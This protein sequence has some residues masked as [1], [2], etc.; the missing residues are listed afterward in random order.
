MLVVLDS[1]V[2]VRLHLLGFIFSLRLSVSV[3]KWIDASLVCPSCF[4]MYTSVKCSP[5]LLYQGSVI[6]NS[7]A[8][9]SMC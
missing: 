5:S 4:V 6:Y 1:S 9:F 2:S 7:L 3:F 8:F